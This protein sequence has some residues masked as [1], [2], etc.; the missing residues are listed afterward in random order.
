MVTTLALTFT[1]TCTPTPL[2]TTDVVSTSTTS[3]SQVPAQTATLTKAPV[4]IPIP[5]STEVV[6]GSQVREITILY[7]ND[8]QGWM[9]GVDEGR[10][11]E[12]LIGVWQ[13]KFG[14]TPEGPFV[15]LSGG[16]MWTGAA[17]STW[18]KG[19]SMVEVMNSMQYAGAALGNHEFDFGLDG[20]SQRTAEMDFPLLA[21]NLYY[22]T[23]GSRPTDLGISPYTILEVNGVRIAIIGLIATLT[24][25]ITFPKYTGGFE[26]EGYREALDKILPEIEKAGVDLILVTAHVCLEELNSLA[27]QI[28]ESGVRMLGG[29]HC[30]EVSSSIVDDIVI[31]EAGHNIENYA[32]ASFSVD[33]ESGAVDVISYGT[34]ANSGGASYHPVEEVISKWTEKSEAD[35][36]APIGYLLCSMDMSSPVLR[37]M[38]VEA[39]LAQFPNTE[40]A[41]TNLGGIRDGFRVGEI[42]VS[43]VISI[44]PFDNTVVR[45]ELTGQEIKNV[46]AAT[47]DNLAVGGMIQQSGRWLLSKTGAP[48]VSNETYTVLINNFMYTENFP[49]YNLD[50]DGYDTQILYRQPLIEWI[51]EQRSDIDHPLDGS[52][53]NLV[54]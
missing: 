33:T 44:L 47:G 39:W 52:I 3:A 17:I 34:G 27:H 38:I 13:S 20:L 4:S 29:G 53:S 5:T 40:I 43:D 21:A 24:P 48:V 2:T 16:D 35:L 37:R 25:G 30:E 26:F 1:T 45:I 42:T 31:I 10:G 50:P 14:Y 15:I 23:D 9:E 11:A 32:Y 19:Q 36:Y 8:E 12:N 46:F 22:Q 51:R 54:K 7:T 41:L 6:P 28:G 18:Y 49:F